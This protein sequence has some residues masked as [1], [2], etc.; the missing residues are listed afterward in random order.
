[1]SDDRGDFEKS[2]EK[3]FENARITPPDSVWNKIE[4]DLDASDRRRGIFFLKLAVAAS[5][6]FAS[7]IAFYQVFMQDVFV[8][9][10]SLEENATDE[11][12]GLLTDTTPENAAAEPAEEMAEQG[13]ANSSKASSD[14]ENQ[15]TVSE[16]RASKRYQGE[17]VRRQT[18]DNS[19]LS[20]AHMQA[21][22][23]ELRSDEGANVKTA[24]DDTRDSQVLFYAHHERIAYLS[25][26]GIE[27][28]V[29]R[30]GELREIEIYP[31]GYDLIEQ[32]KNKRGN[33][34]ALIAGLNFSTGLFDPGVSDQAI[35]NRVNQPQSFARTA[36][37]EY[38]A[39]INSVNGG[40]AINEVRSYE[41]AMAYSY[42]ANVGYKLSRKVILLSGINYV[43]ASSQVN[44]NMNVTQNG[45]RIAQDVVLPSMSNN[46]D[47]NAASHNRVDVSNALEF[48]S[49]PVK[50]GYIVWDRKLNLTVLTGFSADFLLGS[51]YKGK[52]DFS[53]LYVENISGENSVVYEDVYVNGI[54]G[55]NVGYTFAEHYRISVEPS[56]R[57][58][59]NSLINDSDMSSPIFKMVSFGLSYQ[60]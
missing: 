58:S 53:T 23:E 11:N 32:D 43:K 60:F 17:T 12:K 24:S 33:E 8:E 3:A 25:N 16:L 45:E 29:S 54:L 7:S 35:S 28:W 59:L 49:V 26:E 39:G 40:M 46:G 10:L 4:E 50:L 57:Q 9:E 56:L 42:G 20:A 41:Q 37:A 47:F 48:A 38:N 18:P 34:T 13:A 1:M 21:R 2:W 22:A 31:L 27:E 36:Y 19:S 55:L 6:V 51:S 5:L 14:V 30:P 15:I 44:S 52:N